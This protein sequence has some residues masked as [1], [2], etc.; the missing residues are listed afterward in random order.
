MATREGIGIGLEGLDR[1]DGLLQEINE[2]FSHFHCLLETR[3]VSLIEKVK[4]MR[5]L[6]QQHQ[7]LLEAIKQLEVVRRTTNE[8]LKMNL[9]AKEKENTIK[10]WDDKIEELT[11]KKADLE[12]VSTL[13]LVENDEFSDCVQRIH[14]REIEAV[15]YCKRREP[16]VMKGNIGYGEG[17]VI[18]PHGISID[19]ASNEVFVVDYYKHLVCVYSSEGNFMRKFGEKQLNKPYGICLSGEFLFVSNLS[20]SIISKFNKTGEFVKSTSLEGENAI[21]LKSPKGLCVHNEF[22]YICN[23]EHNRI[24]VL[25]LDLTFVSNFGEDELVNPG[26]IKLIHTFSTEQFTHSVQS[27]IISVLFISQDY[28]VRYL[29]LSFLQ[30]TMEVI[31]LFATEKLVVCKH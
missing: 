3:R 14:L 23:K 20:S 28:R 5:E 11:G 22:L 9:T 4:K 10:I 12:L 13:K 2:K 30:L 7:E 25:K 6:Y 26:D 16:L 24:E 27:T 8:V 17:E 19:D 31:L 21:Q 18:D 1:F 15:E 29:T